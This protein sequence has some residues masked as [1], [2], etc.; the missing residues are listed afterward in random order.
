MS[1]FEKSV[2]PMLS[3]PL[4]NLHLCPTP[5]LWPHQLR[6]ALADLSSSGR[7]GEEAF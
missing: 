3:P 5:S 1:P 7:L 4:P 6:N 2:S